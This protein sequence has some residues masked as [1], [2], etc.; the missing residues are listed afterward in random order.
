MS[1]DPTKFLQFALDTALDAVYVCDKDGRIYYVN[2]SAC[3]SLG[4]SRE[5]LLAM[6]IFDI[7]PNLTRS[8]WDDNLETCRHTGGLTD[9][10]G[11]HR[12]KDGSIIAVEVSFNLQHIDGVEYS[13]S[14]V[15]NISERKAAAQET[16][17]LRFAVKNATEAV[18]LYDKDAR[19]RYVN[20][21]ACKSLGYSYE[22]LNSMK[23]SDIDPTFN[24]DNWPQRWR[25]A[26]QGIR[27]SI[28]GVHRRKDG[29]TFPVEIS[30]GAEEIKDEDYAIAFARDITDRKHTEE[31]LRRYREQLEELVENRTAELRATQEELLRKEKLAVLGQLTGTVGH[32]L[33]N[34]L[35]TIRSSL[36]LIR[37]SVPRDNAA[38][39]RALQRA[40]RNIVRCDKLIDELL[41]FTRTRELDLE[42][43][44]LDDWLEEVVLS[45]EM[46]EAIKLEFDLASDVEVKIDKERFRRCVINMLSNACDA[47]MTDDADKPKVLR[48]STKLDGER[49]L[50]DIADTGAGIPE[51]KLQKIFE[52][53]FSTKAFGVG[54]GLPIVEQ[55]VQQ[56][57]GGVWIKST[58]GEGT[59]VS[60]WLPEAANG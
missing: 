31:E 4:F 9:I 6:T 10:E 35:G 59:C 37:D 36:Y 8:F 52:P 18:Y 17:R 48:V 23:I 13:C 39:V 28:E 12:R 40:D 45:Y 2:P 1:S 3:V 46:P 21:S 41:D 42:T 49:V 19:I 24:M 15:R 29:S 55:I 34:P 60:L 58:E 26:R 25:A 20:T 50:I 56:H 22:E 11:T 5:E 7:D 38:V 47:M 57:H 16:E 32:E 43:T 53:L 54:L 44:Q 33:R 27:E 30:F 14:V 51:E